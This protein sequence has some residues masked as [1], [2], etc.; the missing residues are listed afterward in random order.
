VSAKNKEDS[1]G[2]LV[3]ENGKMEI[4]EGNDEASTE[5]IDMVNQIIYGDVEKWVKIYGQ[6]GSELVE[7]IKSTHEIPVGIYVTPKYGYASSYW[8][9]SGDRVM[10]TGMIDLKNV[11]Q[12]SEVDWKVIRECKIKNMR[13]L[14]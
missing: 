13:I 4:F 8:D 3:H 12:E 6:H 14:G 1:I 7:K 9:M 5:T 11:S 10:F 2:I